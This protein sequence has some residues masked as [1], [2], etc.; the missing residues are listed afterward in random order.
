M[1]ATWPLGRPPGDP[2]AS[3]STGRGRRRQ[4]LSVVNMVPAPGASRRTGPGLLGLAGA[5]VGERSGRPCARASWQPLRDRGGRWT[6]A[7]ICVD[8]EVSTGSRG[9]SSSSSS[10]GLADPEETAR[11]VQQSQMHSLNPTRVV[12][13][14]RRRTRRPRIHRRAPDRPEPSSGRGGGGPDQRPRLDL[15]AVQETMQRR[16]RRRSPPGPSPRAEE[17]PRRGRGCADGRRRR[18]RQHHVAMVGDGVDDEPRSPAPTSA[19]PPQ[20]GPTSPQ[21]PQNDDPHPA[22]PT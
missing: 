13:V 11:R 8:H 6:S 22:A 10:G 5:R 3:S 1:V 18:S 9:S 15:A 21:G 2:R 19:S 4:V 20:A 14:A 12:S 17:T 7:G 16:R